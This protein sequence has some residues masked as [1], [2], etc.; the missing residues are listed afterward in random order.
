M[1]PASSVMTAATRTQRARGDVGCE[2]R[3]SLSDEQIHPP[4]AAAADACS[5]SARCSRMN[6]TGYITETHTKTKV[7]YSRLET[8]RRLPPVRQFGPRDV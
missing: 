1:R 2:G 6:R 5:P 4:A 8:F 3:E 7:T